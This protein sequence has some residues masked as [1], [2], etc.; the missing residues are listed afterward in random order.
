[1]GNGHVRPDPEK[2]KAVKEYP[3]PMSKKQVRGFLGLAGYY[4]RFIEN[5]ATVAVP[6]TDLTK[7]S[8]SDSVV[9]TAECEAS[10]KDG[11]VSITCVKK[12]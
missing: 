4:R 2:I 9:W 6:L 11:I 3:V 10:F 1:M 12:P 8:M 5:Y 7:K